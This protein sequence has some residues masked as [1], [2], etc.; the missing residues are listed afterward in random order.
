[1]SKLKLFTVFFAVCIAA[2]AAIVTSD[3]ETVLP[4]I[5]KLN[6]AGSHCH[7]CVASAYIECSNDS[8]PQLKGCQSGEP[9]RQQ[10][11]SAALLYTAPL[12]VL[13]PT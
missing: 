3:C 1:M 4:T 2:A 8:N 7:P 12:V 5:C 10:H 6:G 13:L 11:L 9:W